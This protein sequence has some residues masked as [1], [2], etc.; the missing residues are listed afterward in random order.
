MIWTP[1]LLLSCG[2]GDAPPP[3]AAAPDAGAW[4]VP[5]E[6]VDGSVIVQARLGPDQDPLRLVL[7]TSSPTLLRVEIA[8]RHGLQRQVLGELDDGYGQAMVAGLA[9]LPTLWLGAE[10][11]DGLEALVVDLPALDLFCPPVDG[12]LGTGLFPARSVLDRHPF[13]LD[14]AGQTLRLAHSS[15][16]LAPG[17]TPVALRRRPLDGVPQG[18]VH[19]EV[20][21]TVEGQASW[22]ELGIGNDSETLLTQP[23]FEALGR[24]VG[25]PGQVARHGQIG[26]GLGGPATGTEWLAR[27]GEL[28]LGELALSGVPVAVEPSEFAEAMLGFEFLRHFTVVVDVPGGQAR[29]IPRGGADPSAARHELGLTWSRGEPTHTITGL[30]QGSAAE[31]AGLQLGDELLRLAG[32]ELLPGDHASGCAAYAAAEVWRDSPVPV[33]VRRGEETLEAALGWRPNLP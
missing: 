31:E 30:L 8:V 1:L 7:S 4:E 29:W 15:D 6:V 19:L 24:Q 5:V 9:A 33:T 27:I 11:L 32:V 2:A 21:A 18:D 20:Q 22:L 28:T 14:L 16:A 3:E 25:G 23:T 13:E 10:P 17:G 12:V 26:I